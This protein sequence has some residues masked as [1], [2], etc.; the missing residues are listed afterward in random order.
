MNK[1]ELQTYIEEHIPIIKKMNF[2][3]LELEPE[4]KIIGLY[5]E[6]INHRN[7]VFGGSIASLLTLAGWAKMKNLMDNY[8][9]KATIVIQNSEIK[10]LKPVLTDFIAETIQVDEK[11]LIKSLNMFKKKNKMRLDLKVVLKEL[12]KGEVLAEFIG[13]FVVVNNEKI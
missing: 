9:D 11:I 4:V 7:S 2:N 10:Y 1:N 6:H 3:I 5:D 13:R 12:N 8:D